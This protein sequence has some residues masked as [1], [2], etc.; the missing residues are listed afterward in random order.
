MV[1]QY[2]ALGQESISKNDFDYA[3]N[4]QRVYNMLKDKYYLHC[5]HCYTSPKEF[6]CGYCNKGKFVKP[7]ESEQHE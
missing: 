6:K 5:E 4:Y 1:L 2:M 7:K 3:R